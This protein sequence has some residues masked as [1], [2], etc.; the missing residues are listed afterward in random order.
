M[1]CIFNIFKKP[2][3]FYIESIKFQKNDIKDETEITKL[4]CEYEKDDESLDNI[5]EYLD[6]L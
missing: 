4:L 6:C 1:G 2:R 5:E 3:E